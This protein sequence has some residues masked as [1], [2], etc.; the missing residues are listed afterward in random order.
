[1]NLGADSMMVFDVNSIFFSSYAMTQ[2]NVS[3]IDNLK[4]DYSTQTYRR[5]LSDLGYSFCKRFMDVTISFF[6]LLALSPLFL[7]VALAIKLEDGGPVFFTQKRWG[8]NQKQIKIFK[9]RSMF[10]DKCDAAGLIQAVPNDPRTTKVGAFVRRTN[11]DELP[12]LINVLMGEM[13]IVGPRCHPIGMLAAGV[14]YETLIKNYHKR[15]QVKPGI[16][17]L[18]QVRGYRGPT[19]DIESAK[20]RILNDFVYLKNKSIMLDLMIIWKT[21][22]NELRGG[23]GF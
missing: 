6:S 13:S 9:F 16:T 3:S 17:G 4:V 20:G 10:V 1:M 18:A 8:E 12:Q 11:I 7:F 19:T 15:H 14:P 23:K 21:L 22:T 2:K 5:T